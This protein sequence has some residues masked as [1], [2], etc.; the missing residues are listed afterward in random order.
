MGSTGALE[1]IGSEGLAAERCDMMLQEYRN[2]H[3]DLLLRIRSRRLGEPGNL[4]KNRLIPQSG[5]SGRRRLRV[6]W[7]VE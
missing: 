2:V 6:E 5:L 1:A 3:G 4:L 7:G